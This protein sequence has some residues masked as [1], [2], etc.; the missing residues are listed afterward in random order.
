MIDDELCQ[1]VTI[2]LEVADGLGVDI[3]AVAALLEVLRHFEHDG[4][5]PFRT[6]IEI[7]DP[8]TT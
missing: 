4:I 2:T 1:R 6:A 8:T 7:I 3:V 5:R